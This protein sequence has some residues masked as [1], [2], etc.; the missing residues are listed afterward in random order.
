MSGDNFQVGVVGGGPCGMMTAL[1]LARS[2]VKSVVFERKPGIS[3]HPKAMGVSRRTAEIYRQIGLLGEIEKGS[4]SREGRWLALWAKSL[5]GEELGRQPLVDPR[6]PTTP[7]VALHCPQTWTEQVLW[8]A[9]KNEPLVDLRFNSEVTHIENLAE[10]VKLTLKSG[11][12]L[13]VPWMVAADGAGSLVR[14]E[15]NVET[16]GPGDMGH[17]I[18]TMFRANY[19]KHLT[20]RPMVLY[21]ILSEDFFEGFVVVNGKD[22]W[23]MHHFL[24]PGEKAEDFSKERLAEMIKRASGLPDEPVEVLSISP[25]VMSP[26]VAKEFRKGRVLFVG[27]AAARVS[28]AGGLGLNTGLQSAHNLAWKLA[29]VVQGKAGEK[30]LDTYTEERQGVAMRIMNASNKNAE[31]MYNTIVAG[32]SGNWDAAREMI[33]KSRRVGPGL[34]LD[35]GTSYEAGALIPDGTQPAAVNNPIHDYI[36]EARPGGRAPHV[37][38]ED[39]DKKKVSTLDWFGDGFCLVCGSTKTGWPEAAEEF[40]VRSVAVPPEAK[41]FFASYGIEPGGA[42]LVRPDGYVAARWKS[43]VEDPEQELKKAL[44]TMLSHGIE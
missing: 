17:F 11:E 21:N 4:L 35:L 31:E 27:D 24:E 9:L 38:I 14:R 19:G 18:N 15:L 22:L 41:E 43:F 34:G 42:V 2:G 16:A 8:E 28:P 37:W 25:W 32:R 44:E 10:S 12:T 3:T 13:E 1:L 20:D 7:C 39:G 5:V 26:K 29:L 33:A 30:L 36:P 23:L 6:S 40:E